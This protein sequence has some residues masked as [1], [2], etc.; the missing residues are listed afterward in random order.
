MFVAIP[1]AIPVE[2]LINRF[3][4]L[5]GNTV[6]SFNDPSKLSCIS[7]VSL[8]KSKRSSSEI[9]ESFA[10]VYLMEAAESPSTFPKL[11]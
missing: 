10:S 8:F 6:G 7:T 5:A 3:G 1:T 4:N 11:P 2:P 9:L